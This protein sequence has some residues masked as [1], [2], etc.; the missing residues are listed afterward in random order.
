MMLDLSVK[1]NT[2]VRENSMGKGWVMFIQESERMPV[3]LELESKEEE[4]I[5]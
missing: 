1:N 5:A 3:R 4:D 2:S